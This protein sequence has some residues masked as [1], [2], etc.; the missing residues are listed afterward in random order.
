MALSSALNCFL[1]G[2]FLLRETGVDQSAEMLNGPERA[3]ILQVYFSNDQWS[4]STKGYQS[5]SM[6][7]NLLQVFQISDTMLPL[8]ETIL[9][10]KTKTKIQ[11]QLCHDQRPKF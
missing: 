6:V 1:A 10:S 3:D 4:A 9:Q 5:C 7:Y 8:T 2:V 11:W